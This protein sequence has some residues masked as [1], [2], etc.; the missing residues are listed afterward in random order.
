MQSHNLSKSAAIRSRLDHP[1]IDS[2]GHQ[3]EAGPLFFDYLRAEA[4][5]KAI[6]G[7]TSVTF[8]GFPDQSWATLSRQERHERRSMRPTWWATPMRN[9]R[10]LATAM[11]PKLFHER[12]DELGLDL[13]V[14]YPTLGLIA[15]QIADEE[16]RRAA[17]RA[18]NKMKAE[19][20]AGYTDR[21]L[22]VATI[23]MHTP[24]EAIEE[25]EFSVR[26]LGM[27]A[28]MMASYVRR[29]VKA[30]VR[31]SPEAARYSYWLDTYGLD[32][33]Y[34]YDPVWA[35][36]L[37][38]KV[39]PTFHSVG[40]SW[41]SR[42]TPS[43]YIHNH[44]GNFAASADAVC[45]GLLLGGVPKRFPQLTFAF[46]EGGVAWARTLQCDLLS[47]WEKRNWEAV[48]NYNPAYADQEVFRDLCRQYGDRFLT[49]RATE[50]LTAQNYAMSRGEDPV[51]LD[52][53]APSGIASPEDIN[54]I[55]TDQL[56]FGCEG[57]DPLNALAF[58]T[59]GLPA[60]ARLHA[61]YG[62]DLGHWDVPDMAEAAEEAHELVEE[63][64][65]ATTDFRDL[66]FIDPARFWTSTNPDFFK[67]T[68]VKDAV[69]KALW[70]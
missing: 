3:L 18:L 29:P 21:L 43:N 1:I 14:I 50:V 7:F 4:G 45:R 42:A 12:M 10:D 9:T 57:D 25:L 52:E 53:W 67:D 68:I 13:S 41:G 47:H 56:Y 61:L 33:E 5:A 6:E 70:K 39:S 63:G 32:S 27:R 16:V 2:D 60:E 66:V 69:N 19:M 30:A 48:Q 51:M 28:V 15:V 64:V 34:D 17:A 20:F 44:L 26:E 31:I 62:S 49:H 55:F 46:M 22:P 23:P 58:D 11:F 36:C 38:L 54:R 8:D 24:R 40:Y 35:K 37:E 59:K 65:I